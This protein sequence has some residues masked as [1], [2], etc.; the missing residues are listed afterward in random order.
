M[1]ASSASDRDRET[2]AVVRCERAAGNHI[3]RLRHAS[4]T[5]TTVTRIFADNRRPYPLAYS[6]V[7]EVRVTAAPTAPPANSA[8]THT[9]LSCENR[10]NTRAH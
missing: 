7:G 1:I 10:G 2:T 5:N 6:C 4:T 9:R 8:P 3:V